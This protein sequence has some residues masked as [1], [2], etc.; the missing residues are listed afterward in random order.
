MSLFQKSKAKTR[1]AVFLAA[2]LSLSACATSQDVASRSDG[3]NDPYE[4]QNRKVH[5]FNKGFDKNVFRPVSQGYGV[6]PVEMRNTINNF[7]ENLDMPGVAVNSL[8]QGDLRGTGLATLRFVLNTTI[9][10]GGF[11]DAADELNIPAHDTNF[12]ET[13]AVWGVGEGAYIELPFLGPSTQR[14]TAGL[15][16]DFFTNPLTY[17][18][19]DGDAR[20]IPPTS[21]GFAALNDRERFSDSFDSVLYGSADSYSQSRLIY[22]QNRRFE[23]GQ[24]AGEDIDPFAA[25]PYEDPYA[26]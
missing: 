18:T 22:L 26:E 15:V 6:V 9:G 20:I 7:S 8:L 14:A 16:V 10:L 1:S 21:K 5:A 13:L 19:I 11:F 3:I 4:P 12:G 24:D 25:D 2:A 23:L 17:N